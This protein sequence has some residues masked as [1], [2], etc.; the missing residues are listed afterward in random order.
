MMIEP[1]PIPSAQL[2]GT[3]Y[4]AGGATYGKFLV[5]TL[6]SEPSS[7]PLAYFCLLEPLLVRYSL[8]L[9]EG[10]GIFFS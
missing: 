9:L 5:L 3:G 2:L 6:C 1:F 10:G 4:K 8:S 7:P